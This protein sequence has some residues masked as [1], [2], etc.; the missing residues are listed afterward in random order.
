MGD[1]EIGVESQ[2]ADAPTDAAHAAEY[3][4]SQQLKRH[5]QLS[6]PGIRRRRLARLILGAVGAR[7]RERKALDGAVLL[8]GVRRQAGQM[9][10]ELARRRCRLA[11]DELAGELAQ[12]REA[13]VLPGRIL[14][15]QQ[16]SPPCAQALD[17]LADECLGRQLLEL[18]GGAP[19][20]LDETLDSFARLRR[21]LR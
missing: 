14:W 17:Q 10:H 13:R 4:F 8:W 3:L 1:V 19:M 16:R 2:L 21:N 7:R 5:L 9:A 15:R 11:A 12:L 18:C 20:Q 6:G